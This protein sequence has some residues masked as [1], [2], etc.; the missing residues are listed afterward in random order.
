MAL[1]IAGH[2]LITLDLFFNFFPA[3]PEFIAMWGIPLWAKVLWA[4]LCVIGVITFIM[5]Y[6][7]P[8]LGFA[9][10][11]AF[12]AFLYFASIQLWGEVKGGF[13]LAIITAL[14]AAVSAVGSNNSFKPNL[15]RKSA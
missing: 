13:W 8:W 14:L 12:C 11:A 1:L 7:R 4:T 6:R 15:L 2:L 9:A 10:S 5:I 3:T